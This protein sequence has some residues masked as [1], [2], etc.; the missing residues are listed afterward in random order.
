MG[1][2]HLAQN[3]PGESVPQL[4]QKAIV[5]PLSNNSTLYMRNPQWILMCQDRRQWLA[6]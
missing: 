5:P 4:G 3:F 2:P 1:D 6:S